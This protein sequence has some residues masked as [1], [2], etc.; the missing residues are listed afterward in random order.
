MLF[1]NVLMSAFTAC[2][3]SKPESYGAVISLSSSAQQDAVRREMVKLARAIAKFGNEDVSNIVFTNRS[4][5]SGTN[6]CRLAGAPHVVW[7]NADE[8]SDSSGGVREGVQAFVGSCT[9]SLTIK[10]AVI[11]FSPE[12]VAFKEFSDSKASHG[13]SEASGRVEAQLNKLKAH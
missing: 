4:S 5:V 12:H 11:G 6:L 3:Y 13:F 8:Y 7:V 2:N 1:G 10:H 9:F